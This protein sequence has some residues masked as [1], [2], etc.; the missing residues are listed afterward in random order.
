MT[1]SKAHRQLLPS[2]IL[3]VGD[4]LFFDGGWCEIAGIANVDFAL[5]DAT[6]PISILL[7]RSNSWG[8]DRFIIREAHY[9]KNPVNEGYHHETMIQIVGVLNFLA[10]LA[11]SPYV[12]GYPDLVNKFDI[13]LDA[14]SDLY[15]TIGEKYIVADDLYYTAQQ[16]TLA[17][18]YVRT[19]HR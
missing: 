4:Y 3:T 18:L 15:Q 2:T 10:D 9:S 14:L 19:N 16:E 5:P 6:M 7:L 11:L 12:I 13:V 8:M 17:N 1:K